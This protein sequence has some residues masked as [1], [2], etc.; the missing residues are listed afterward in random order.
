MERQMTRYATIDA[1]SG[2][3]WWVGEAENP[4]DA[5]EKS[6]AATGGDQSVRYEERGLNGTGISYFVHEVPAGYDVADGQAQDEIE[7]VEAFRCVGA[8]AAVGDEGF[9]RD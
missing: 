6:T 8:F 7:A 4:I 5:C 2:F 3:V 9:D 1:H